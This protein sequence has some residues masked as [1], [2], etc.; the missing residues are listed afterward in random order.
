MQKVLEMQGGSAP[1]CTDV[2]TLHEGGGCC[3]KID[4]GAHDVQSK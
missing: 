4:E 3:V 1:D 2:R